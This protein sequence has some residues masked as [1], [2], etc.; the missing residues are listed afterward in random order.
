MR[1]P[2]QA[3][4]IDRGTSGREPRDPEG[5]TTTGREVRPPHHGIQPS[6]SIESCVAR[7][8]RMG[9]TRGEASYKC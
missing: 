9:Y 7:Y 4:P 2:I 5:R 6:E 8:M 3:R 1:L